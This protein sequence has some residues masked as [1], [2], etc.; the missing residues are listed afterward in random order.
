MSDCHHL[1]V[2]IDTFLL[3]GIFGK[4][5]DKCIEIYELDPHYFYAALGLAWQMCLKNADVKLEL[6]SDYQMLLR[7]EEGIREE[8][9]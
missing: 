7:I 8:I 3:A 5:R 1:Y 6:L 2:Q 9:C 4:F